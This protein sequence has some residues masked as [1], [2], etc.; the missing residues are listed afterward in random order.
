M[1]EA[2]CSSFRRKTG[3][4]IEVQRAQVKLDSGSCPT[5]DT[6]G[7]TGFRHSALDAEFMLKLK[8]CPGEITMTQA[9]DFV[10]TRID[11]AK[12]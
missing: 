6:S 10:A 3:N 12:S 8:T 7:T 11:M 9:Y 2:D 4:H 5:A 1:P